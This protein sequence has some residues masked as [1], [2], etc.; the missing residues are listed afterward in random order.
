MKRVTFIILAS[1]LSGCG[2]SRPPELDVEDQWQDAL[3]RLGLFSLYPS[4]EDALPGDFYLLVPPPYGVTATADRVRQRLI[5]GARPAFDSTRFSLLRLG[6]VGAARPGDRRARRVQEMTM[7]DHIAEQQ[8]ERPRI[9]SLPPLTAESVQRQPTNARSS[10]APTAPLD[11]HDTAPFDIGHAD[12]DTRMPRLQRSAIPSLT[13]ARV[14]EA[15]L[16]GIGALG[17]FGLNLASSAGGEVSLTIALRDVQELPIEP[18]RARLLLGQ[19]GAPVFAER[20]TPDD[21]LYWLRVMRVGRYD[22]HSLMGAACTGDADALARQGVQVAVVTRAVYAGAIEYSFSRRTSQAIRAALD[23]QSAIVPNVRLPA[24]IPTIVVNTGPG[25]GGGSGAPAEGQ[26]ATPAASVPTG[27]LVA[28]LAALTGLPGGATARAG[29]QAT[30]GIGTQGALSLVEV[31]N[32][33]IAVGFGSSLFLTFHDALAGVA[34]ERMRQR[35]EETV[36]LCEQDFRQLSAAEKEALW[37]AMNPPDFVPAREV[38]LPRMTTP[39]PARATPGRAAP[40]AAARPLAPAGT[41][42]LQGQRSLLR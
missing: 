31:F 40:A 4:T 16:A 36:R 22:V 8:R 42:T 13:V 10:R 17:N 5:P 12:Q 11:G 24:Q 6:S 37:R 39:A 23:L 2:L 30:F 3:R 27:D 35:Y 25:A 15:Q 18:W 7:L 29:L 19:S 1:L 34:P 21:L 28:R 38:E 41:E 33:P 20:I 9:Q 14:T 32:R 26:G